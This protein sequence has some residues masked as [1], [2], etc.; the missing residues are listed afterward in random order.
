MSGEG[1]TPP[2]K[3]RK[4]RTAAEVR[5]EPVRGA[6]G[7]PAPKG[8]R[9]GPNAM[10]AIVYAVVVVIAFHAVILGGLTFVSPD[11]TAPLGFVRVGET[12]LWKAGVYPLWNPYV[13]AGMPSFASGAYN[14][15]IYPPDW[16]VAV[17]QK[18]LPL[19]DVSWMLLYYFLAG[20]G[21]F[22]LARHWGAGT[23]GALVAGL[24]FMITPNLIANGAHGHG[25]QL[26]NEAYLPWMLW[27]TSR[28]WRDA[29]GADAASLALL[30]G[31]QLL[32][33]HV[34]IAYY[35]WLCI[36]LLSLFEFA[37]RITLPDGVR[38]VAGRIGLLAVALGL[39]FALS[40]FFAL[41]IRAY[42]EHSIRSLGAGGGVAYDYATGWSFSPIE[43][44]TFLVPGAL[45][46]GVPTYWGTMP[47]TDFPNYMG[48]A[49]LALAFLAV[50]AGRRAYHVSFLLVLGAFALLI[51]FGKHSAFYD[52]LFNHLP[53]F[54]KFRVPVMILV[55]VQ[56][57]VALLAGL[58]LTAVVEA[59][60]EER[61]RRRLL[62]WTTIVAVA[63]GLLLA[64]G[65]VPDVWRA[66]YDAAA[67]ASRPGMDSGAIE[68]GYR[69]MIGDIVRVGLL[70]LIALGAL[71]A[72]LRGAI[73]PWA[74]GAVIAVVTLIDLTAVNERVISPVLGPPRQLTVAAERD[75]VVDF[76]L[77]RK[78]EGE[79]FRILPLREFQ[80]NRYAG[81]GLASLGGYHAAKPALYQRFLDADSGRIVQSPGAWRLLN[82]RYLVIP[83][84]L[85]P[86]SGFREA[87]RGEQQV[88]YEFPGAL[89]R[90]T[91]VPAFVVA[92]RDSH[93]AIF[94]DPLHDAAQVTMLTEDPGIVPVPGGV[95]RITE[96]GLNRVAIETE[97]PGP[98]ILR[99]ADLD[100]PGW[101]VSV[102]GRPARLLSADI[103]LR[104]VAVPP[105]RHAV[106][107]AFHDPAF[108]TGLIVSLSAFAA[109]LALYGVSW[110]WGRR[111][112][113]ASAAGPG[114]RDE[115]RS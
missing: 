112:P 55:V 74:A 59:A 38:A 42:A 89:P 71:L 88:V 18:L 50:A 16:P 115:W 5:A 25:S 87:F 92:P 65:V 1:K 15:L 96:Y 30:V 23:P 101:Q 75:D 2:G 37:R 66:G 17:V 34:Q 72:V 32:R 90:V 61:A 46:F 95:A 67:R 24:A 108:E 8:P 110:W 41:P 56:L 111:R 69:A 58:G 76:L 103:M 114:G 29:R 99:L 86:E 109:I 82:V 33:C 106:V 83:G 60:G 113:G 107:F 12:S 11:T 22:V 9:L 79:E 73:R 43:T 31:F 70:A 63:V 3:G 19:P 6:T 93:L 102:D 45:G 81:F 21:T 94:R 53:Y 105:G 52:F 27:L 104:A 28:L 7:A 78:A 47:F 10:A 64:S 51:A 35:A 4:R 80:S 36:G 26:V 14:P 40:A 54:N 77:E 57:A 62:R 48:L 39:G 85:P 68:A 20:L 91:L 13:F 100:F 97:T 44:L 98:S 49:I 84:L